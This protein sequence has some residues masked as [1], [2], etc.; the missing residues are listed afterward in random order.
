MATNPLSR[1]LILALGR[2]SR[3]TFNRLIVGSSEVGDPP[4][5]EPTSFPWVARLEAELPTIRRELDA[6]M[7]DGETLPGVEEISPDHARIARE[8]RWRSFFLYAYGYRSE[9]ACTFCPR[10]A[11][12]MD[13]IPDLETAFF[14]VLRPGAHLPRHRG[15]TKALITC[16]LPL[17]VP[18]DRANCWID[19][20]GERHHWS[21]GQAFVFDDTRPHEVRNDTDDER[22]VLLI[23]VRRPLRPPGS[24]AGNAFLAAVKRSPFIRDGVRNQ[25]AWEERYLVPRLQAR[26]GVAAVFP[27]VEAGDGEAGGDAGEGVVIHHASGE[28]LIEQAP[29]RRDQARA[30]CAQHDVHVGRS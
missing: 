21:A 27:A 1:R 15:V 5:F 23:H 17:A 18:A 3:K 22:V 2:K 11:R 7:A 6:V 9:A 29:D 4:V 30:S 10:T 24:L 16:H 14:S 13:A 26:S 28:A 12:L 25:R 8:R 19:V 20:D